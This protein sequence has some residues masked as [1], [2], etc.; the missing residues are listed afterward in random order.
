MAAVASLVSSVL[1]TTSSSNIFSLFNVLQIIQMVA[2][3][4][5]D[6]PEKLN[7]FYHGFEFT[8]MNTPSELNIVRM[9]FI[10][11]GKD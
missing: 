2:L 11:P 1:S 9:V 3:I 5:L 4:E 10:K 7:Q 6:Y 8:M